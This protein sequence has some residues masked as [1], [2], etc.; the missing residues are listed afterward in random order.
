MSQK[1][2]Q[3][4]LDAKEKKKQKIMSDIFNVDLTKQ[5]KSQQVDNIRRK[6]YRSQE[7]VLE[8]SSELLQK[9]FLER[10]SSGQAEC[11]INEI[12]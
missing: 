5:S 10:E 6:T 11:V 3:K 4:I 8:R 2:H 7:K 9:D 12:K 1:S